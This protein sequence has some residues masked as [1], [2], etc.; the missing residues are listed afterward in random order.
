MAFD[1]DSFHVYL[2]HESTTMP[3]VE[4]LAQQL[5]IRSDAL[6]LFKLAGKCAVVWTA[7]GREL[8]PGDR[9]ISGEQCS[10]LSAYVTTGVKQ[11]ALLV[12][13]ATACGDTVYGAGNDTT[14]ESVRDGKLGSVI[15][16]LLKDVSLSLLWDVSVALLEDNVEPDNV[17]VSHSGERL[18]LNADPGDFVCG[19]LVQMHQ[20]NAGAVLGHIRLV[21]YECRSLPVIQNYIGIVEVDTDHP[22]H[23]EGQSGMLVTTVPVAGQHEVDGLA[24][25]TAKHHIEIAGVTP[26][27]YSL[28]A[29]LRGTFQRLEGEVLIGQKLQFVMKIM[30][31]KDTGVSDSSLDSNRDGLRSTQVLDQDDLDLGLL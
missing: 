23:G 4:Q 21:G 8:C 7:N 9:I 25:L 2:H 19:Q 10:T 22:L 5:Q 27:T 30:Q 3:S 13:H 1:N 28:A 24:M 26:R 31:D 17:I 6:K 20:Q 18:S 11:Y 12:G 29:P 14:S 15:L 16:N